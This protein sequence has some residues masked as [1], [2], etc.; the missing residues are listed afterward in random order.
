MND[1]IDVEDWALSGAKGP[2]PAASAYRVH[3]WDCDGFDE[4]RRLA[5]ATPTGAQILAAFDRH[6]INEHVLLLLDRDGL[7]EIAPNEVIDLGARKA[8]KFLAFRSD[9]VWFGTINE[10][11]FPWGQES[12]SES[13]LRILFRIAP[14][15]KIILERKD[16][17][18]K[19]LEAGDVVSLN[20][21]GVE[22]LYTRKEV[23][24]LLVQGIIL[25]FE[26]PHVV[27][28]DA[29]IKAGLDPDKGWTA[30][31]KLAGQPKERV[32]LN[33]TLDLTRKGIEKLW[34]RPNHVN[35]GESAPALN[36][37][38]AIREADTAFLT[39]RGLDWETLVDLGQHWFIL[40]GYA[41][42]DGY[43]QKMADIAVL[44]PPTYPAAA[45]DMFYCYPSLTLATGKP[46]PC[47]DS[48]QLIRGVSYQRW[49]R[50]R[51][52]DTAWNPAV[53]SLITHI[54]LIDD[55]IAREIE[56][57]E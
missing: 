43:L 57:Y 52:A 44:I 22:Q 18:D 11:R 45:L 26:T 8:E 40:R 10:R 49:S 2:I 51:Q 34:L 48:R 39:E 6:P 7:H 42:P 33:D 9:R 27:V 19:E 13:M 55:A 36:R 31:L 53:D 30:V 24:K 4:K 50:H 14:T 35:N 32:D 54:A 5:D 17:P 16:Q 29:L 25:T 1:E 38:F 56:G 20:E 37:A 15:Q 41:L 12:I 3:L 47:T 28:K 23:W 46:I 21:P